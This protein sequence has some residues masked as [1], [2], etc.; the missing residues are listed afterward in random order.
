VASTHLKKFLAKKK[1]LASILGGLIH[2]GPAPMAIYDSSGSL[3]AGS[4]PLET[5]GAHPILVDGETAGEVRGGAQGAALA[6]LLGFL[7]AEDSVMRAMAGEVL[8]KYREVNLFYSLSEKLSSSPRVET[9]A[10]LGLDAALPLIKADAGLVILARENAP[11]YQV[12]TTSGSPISLKEDLWSEK[13]L[14]TRVLQSGKA[15]I[16]NDADPNRYFLDPPGHP[17]SLLCVPLKTETRLLGAVLFAGLSARQYTAGELQVVNTIAAQI[18]PAIEIVHLQQVAIENARM[19]QELQLA[20]KVQ[21]SLLPL[22]MP[23]V[24]GWEFAAYWQPALEVAGDYYD[25]IREKKDQLGLV[26]ADVTDKGMPASLFMV[27]ARSALR[28]FSDHRFSPARWITRAN[29]LISSESDQGFF[30]T[31]F[32]A[33]L[34]PHSGELTYVNAGHNPP[35]FYRSG[36][37][38]IGQLTRTGIALGVDEN[39]VYEQRTIQLSPGDL[40][41]FYTDGIT[42]AFDPAGAQQ[43]GRQR[44]EEVVL[45]CREANPAEIIR[46]LEAALAA[47]T[48]GGMPSDDVTL[49]VAKRL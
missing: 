4:A 36:I 42:E 47:F 34:T 33:R 49:M 31:L 18:G 32:Y 30:V 44:L 20:R 15:A 43:F 38:Q 16:A 14:V 11:G 41:L 12:I 3:V 19:E 45:R 7:L 10:A 48:G 29:R 1:E 5:T 13:N 9:I 27:F 23:D 46:A 24:P 26:I 28:S 40:I 6:A 37:G 21:A 8:E 25:I 17:V 2:T 22:H 39:A 35:L